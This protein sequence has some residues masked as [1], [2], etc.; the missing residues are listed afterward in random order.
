MGKRWTDGV[1]PS[2]AGVARWREDVGLEPPNG[3]V[4][5]PD[6]AERFE[7]ATALDDLRTARRDEAATVRVL[8]RYAAVRLALRAQTAEMDAG[9]M[10]AARRAAA[11]YVLYPSATSPEA[12]ALARVVALAAP[13]P[14][15][16]LCSALQ[17]AGDA[18][19]A[20]GHGAG[21]R[22]CFRAAYDTAVRF[23]WPAQGATAAR[24]LLALGEAEGCLP[25]V[26]LW[27]RRAR[28]LERRA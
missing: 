26:R 12:L 8:G 28:A 18:A 3:Q 16:E 11:E 27:R 22:S 4:P 21:A 17:S 20:R 19:L 14:P 2:L 25:S 5:R 10:D 24:A 1:P 23:D 9:E 15:K 7:G 6:R 13:A